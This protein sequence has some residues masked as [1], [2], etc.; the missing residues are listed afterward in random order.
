MWGE[1]VPA[2][3]PIRPD[4]VAMYVRWSTDDQS[5]GTTLEV[6]LDG[7]RHYALSQ[8]WAPRDDLTFVDDG[9]SG[10]S[11]E[12]PALSRLR[13]QVRAG[14]VDCVVVFKVDR[15]S[16]NIVDAVDL[17]LGEWR[18]VC[19]F[20]SA[21]EPIDT[22]SDLGRVVFSILAMFADFERSQIRERTQSGKVRRIAE[23]RQLHGEPAYGYQPSGVTGQWAEQPAEAAVVRRIFGLAAAGQSAAAICRQLN[24]EGLRTRAGRPW[25]LRSVL[26]LLQNRTYIGEAVYGR[27]QL[28]PVP[29]AG[30]ARRQVRVRRAAPLVATATRAAPPL[31]T[32]ALFEQ[33]AR[34][35]ALHRT[36]RQ[37]HGPRAAASPHLLTGLARCRCG[38]ALVAKRRQGSVDYICPGT[39]EGR[40]GLSPGHIRGDLVEAALLAQFA[41]LYGP[42][43]TVERLGAALA[44]QG[45]EAAELALQ[46][47]A[48]ERQLAQLDENEA[49]LLHAALAG[50]VALADLGALRQKAAAERASLQERL[51]ALRSHAEAALRQG[52]AVRRQV[53]AT[54]VGRALALLAAPDQRELLRLALA[55]PITLFKPR[56]SDTVEADVAW[57]RCAH[58]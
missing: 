12:R 45:H 22:S 42:D 53:A 37:S 7:C 58:A 21:R 5:E 18:E 52:E 54:G 3:L 38:A 36:A 35:L 28:K 4:R 34:S 33:A 30:G 16:R 47:S 8:G 1:E 15:L 9:Y 24:G 50:E 57:R 20:K 46:E 26:W 2:M 43:L 44:R 10:A 31:V 19:Y 23:G 49:R 41:A 48:L 51:G 13:Q 6:Q 29:A 11:L 17:V 27:T 32:R 39:R 55:G 40:C 25:S 56:G 14:E